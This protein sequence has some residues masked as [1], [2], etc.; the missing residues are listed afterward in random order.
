VFIIKV[1]T[2]ALRR[3]L[4]PAIVKH[5]LLGYSLLRHECARLRMIHARA[6]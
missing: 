1:G 5:P 3:V 4:P 6:A 2:L